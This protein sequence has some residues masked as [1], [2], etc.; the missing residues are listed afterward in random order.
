[1]LRYREDAEQHRGG[2]GAREGIVIVRSRT[3]GTSASR[4]FPSDVIYVPEL[5]D[6]LIP[7]LLPVPL[8]LL[9]YHNRPSYGAATSISRAT[10]AKSVTVE[11][12]R[13]YHAQACVKRLLEHTRS[14]DYA[15]SRGASG[16]IDRTTK[17]PQNHGDAR[18]SMPPANEPVAVRR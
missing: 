1:V 14:A 13:M 10:W 4:G 18:A 16:R 17:A 15:S 11:M 2:A 9:A 3:E 5:S 7:L 6:Y 8:Q 12:I